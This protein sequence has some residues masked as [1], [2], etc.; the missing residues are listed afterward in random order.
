MGYIEKTLSENEYIVHRAHFHWTYHATA[1]AALIFLGLFIIGL[2]IFAQ[3]MWRILTTQLA[4]TNHR[5][6]LKTGFFN[7]TTQELELSSIE[8]VELQQNLLGRIFGFGR[9]IVSGTGIEDLETPLIADPLAL[10]RAI[11][12]AAN[13]DNTETVVVPVAA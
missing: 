4:V 2:I 8:S 6:A 13:S 11:D 5:I 12:E 9:L 3:M 7:R 10:R 1:W